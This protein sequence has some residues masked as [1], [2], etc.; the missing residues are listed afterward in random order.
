MYI[1]VYNHIHIYEIS[2]IPVTLT[3]LCE[4]LYCNVR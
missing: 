4:R 2:L 3:R 1:S